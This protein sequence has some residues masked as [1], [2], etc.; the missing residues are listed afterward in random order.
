MESEMPDNTSNKG[1]RP[2]ID[3]L[4]HNDIV[5][6]ISIFIS[7]GL[8]FAFL[9][10]CEN[11]TNMDITN[12][13]LSNIETYILTIF[14]FFISVIVSLSILFLIFC[15]KNSGLHKFFKNKIIYCIVLF[16]SYV[17]ILSVFFKTESAGNTYSIYTYYR[18]PVPFVCMSVL[19]MIF[20]FASSYL[21]LNKKKRS[22]I[23]RVITSAI[24]LCL[25]AFF[26]YESNP[27][28][29]MGGGPYHIEA[30]VYSIFNVS[31]YVPY[32]RFVTG[33]Y[34]HYAIFYLI[35]VK[36]ISLFVSKLNAVMICVAFFGLLTYLFSFMV[37]NKLIKNDV[38]FA[39][40][41][42]SICIFS[43]MSAGNYYQ[44]FPHRILFQPI[45]LL[46]CLYIIKKQRLSLL[47]IFIGYV[48]ATLSIIWNFEVGLICLATLV[49]CL[50]I[51]DI[52]VQKKPIFTS[53]LNK[54][55]C[56]LWSITA[57]YVLVNIY[58]CLCGGGWID[59]GVFIYPLGSV[60][61]DV[62]DLLQVQLDLPLSNYFMAIALFLG[63]FTYSLMDI[64][65]GRITMNHVMIMCMACLGLGVMVYYI[66]RPV[67][68]N[69]Y[70]VMVPLIIT[71][72]LIVDIVNEKQLY[73]MPFKTKGYYS[74]IS[75]VCMLSLLSMCL[76]SFVSIKVSIDKR[77]ESS[78]ERV[79]YD[80]FIDS[81]EVPHNTAFVGMYTGVVCASINHENIIDT[82]D[83]E[84]INN[85]G[86][87]YVWKQI[88][89][90]EIE[91]VFINSDL[92]EE[93]EKRYPDSRVIDEYIYDGMAS[94]SLVK[95]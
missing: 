92:L 10:L 16:F 35:P 43:F 84:D 54:I 13:R 63:A 59:F 17:F 61:Y 24:L 86:W 45:I 66:N 60:E 91:Y 5:N 6:I 20:W 38:I 82:M 80:L 67:H 8:I 76:M 58:N 40:G 42:I 27:F 33:I 94:F 74:L 41:S 18:L 57:A 28:K 15:D 25:C 64:C 75:K 4:L 30:Y 78:Y 50:L 70:I 31:D 88:E 73:C 34:G 68:G 44:L 87:D 39:V 89:D 69:L 14:V 3:K 52:Y 48:I 46:Y 90:A 7:V 47:N 53:V 22:K 23:F 79:S 85:G 32:S 1:I 9:Y 11:S 83:W 55:I 65:K 71:L 26:I 81:I 21:I 56:A 51:F 77:L 19:L 36:I 2:T 37:L 93:T 95:K 12:S 62:V 49:L 29:D 72:A